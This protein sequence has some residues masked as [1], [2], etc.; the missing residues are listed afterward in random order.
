VP[1]EA[2]LSLSAK[3]DITQQH[4][5]DPVRFGKGAQ[6][7]QHEAG[8]LDGQLFCALFQIGNSMEAPR[9]KLAKSLAA[10]APSAAAR[11]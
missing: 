8:L 3:L 9:F 5:F 1:Q 7:R 2:G 11:A 4:R 6:G 10:G